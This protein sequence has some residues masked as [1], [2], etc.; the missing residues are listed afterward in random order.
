[1]ASLL[2]PWMSS[3]PGTPGKMPQQEDSGFLLQHGEPR[4]VPE[5]TQASVD[6][7]DSACKS[8]G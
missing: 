7:S 8:R 5:K 4:Q 1:M 2:V 3:D 6:R